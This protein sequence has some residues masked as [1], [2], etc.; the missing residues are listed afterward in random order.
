MGGGGGQR[1]RQHRCSRGPGVIHVPEQLS[2]CACQVCILSPENIPINK[3]GENTSFTHTGE[4][5]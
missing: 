3:T 4:G 2:P 1:G 5:L